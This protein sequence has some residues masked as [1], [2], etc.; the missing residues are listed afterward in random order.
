MMMVLDKL[1]RS[2]SAIF[3]RAQCKGLLQSLLQTARGTRIY[4]LKLVPE[5][6]QQRFADNGISCG[7]LPQSEP[8]LFTAAIQSQRD[9]QA[10]FAPLDAVDE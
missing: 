5:V 7:S 6:G 1:I 9:N 4:L 2:S 3:Q 10:L 8:V